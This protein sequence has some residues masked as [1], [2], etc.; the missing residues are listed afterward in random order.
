MMCRG[1]HI[2]SLT[3]KLVGR[4]S[5]GGTLA[6]LHIEAEARLR[7]R[8][9]MLASNV[10]SDTEN[11]IQN[12]EYRKSKRLNT[13]TVLLFPY[14]VSEA[15]CIQVLESGVGRTSASA[16]LVV[17]TQPKRASDIRGKF[18]PDRDRRS[19]GIVH[20]Y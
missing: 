13:R 15:L 6:I 11:G 20:Y 12:T 2:A 10:T 8:C 17:Y 1:R 9:Q 5:A 14:S 16:V 7:H 18:D 4:K 19:G 3:I